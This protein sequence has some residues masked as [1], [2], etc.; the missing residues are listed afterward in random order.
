MNN[1][2]VKPSYLLI[3]PLSFL[4]PLVFALVLMLGMKAPPEAAFVASGVYLP[5]GILSSVVL[6]DSLR[7]KESKKQQRAF[8]IA[9]LLSLPFGILV[10]IYYSIK[11]GNALAGALTGGIFLSTITYIVAFLQ[12]DKSPRTISS[13][14]I[15]PSDSIDANLSEEMENEK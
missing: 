7:K 5:M 12:R 15:L 9:Y 3:L 10:A 13:S 14:E 4:V 1:T 2:F 11:T 6:V 8:W